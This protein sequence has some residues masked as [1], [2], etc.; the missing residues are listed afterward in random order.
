MRL[1]QFVLDNPTVL[2]EVGEVEETLKWG[3]QCQSKI[4]GF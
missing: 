4:A 2:V 1:H 3:C